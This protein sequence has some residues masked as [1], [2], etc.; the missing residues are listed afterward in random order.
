MNL[1][2]DHYRVRNAMQL[3]NTATNQT[4]RLGTGG[5]ESPSP[6]TFVSAWAI[7]RLV[8]FARFLY[9]IFSNGVPVSESRPAL[10]S[11]GGP[12]GPPA[13]ALPTY[14]FWTVRPR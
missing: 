5:N 2:K 13:V 10:N 9:S 6:P 11:A 8:L 3:Q 1:R 4:G 14:E 12:L 7:G